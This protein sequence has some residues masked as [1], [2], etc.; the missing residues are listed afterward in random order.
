M[1]PNSKEPIFEKSQSASSIAQRVDFNTALPPEP[2]IAQT[3]DLQST[4]RRPATDATATNDTNVEAHRQQGWKLWFTED[5]IAFFI[6]G[7]SFALPCMLVTTGANDMF[8][9]LTG[10]YGIAMSL[11]AAVTSFVTPLLLHYIPHSARILVALTVSIL[12]S[13]V[14]TLGNSVAG[15]TVGTVLSGFVYAF[16]TNIHLSTAAFYDTRTVV[17]FSAGSG[18]SAIVGPGIYIGLVQAFSGKWRR[19]LLVSTPFPFVQPLVWWLMLSKPGRQHAESTRL[20][21]KQKAINS[22]STS[23]EDLSMNLD[24][25]SSEPVDSTTFGLGKSRLGLF[26]QVLLPR[27]VVPLSLCT[28]G[29]MFNLSGLSPTFDH[30]KLFQKAPGNELNYQIGFLAYGTAQFLFSILTSMIKFPQIYV[31]ATLQLTVSAIGVVQLFHPF[32]TYYGVWVAFM[33]ITGGIVGG[34]VANTNLKIARELEEKAESEEVR[35][36]A[37]GYGGL[38]NFT[39]DTIGGVLAIVVETLAGRHLKVRTGT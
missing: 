15:P 17:A 33:F 13:I 30:L 39:G 10:I 18:C 19:A 32:L 5:V 38:G 4:N 24:S 31:W 35:S 34:A 16:G 1:E 36:F 14:C 22:N 23:V 9:G 8:S 6:Q 12:C 27:Y 11:A 26:F 21:T 7:L 25:A 2:A 37:M 29:A 20:E 3:Q 28:M